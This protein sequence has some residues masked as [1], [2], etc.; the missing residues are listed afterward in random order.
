[1]EQQGD[2]GLHKQ[3]IGRILRKGNFNQKG[4]NV[5]ELYYDN[6]PIKRA[7][8]ERRLGREEFANQIDKQALQQAALEGDDESNKDENKLL[9]E[10]EEG[11]IQMINL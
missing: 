10:D 5:F 6:V 9:Q 7:L 1:M 2:P 8:H 3:I 11:D 4:V